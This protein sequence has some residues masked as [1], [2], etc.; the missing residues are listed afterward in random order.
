[1]FP[2]GENAI[3]GVDVFRSGLICRIAIGKSQKLSP[4]YEN[5]PI[6]IY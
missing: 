5:T 1:M 6:L 3:V 2:V 4:H